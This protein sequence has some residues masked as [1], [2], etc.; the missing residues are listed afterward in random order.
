ML[1][2]EGLGKFQKKIKKVRDLYNSDKIENEIGKEFKSLVQQTFNDKRSPFGK[3]WIPSSNPD[4]LVDT[5][6]LFDSVDYEIIG[7]KVI[8][9][10]GKGL[11]YARVHNNGTGLFPERQFL[12]NEGKL[13]REWADIAFKIIQKEIRKE[14]K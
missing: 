8:V 9:S 14:I 12:P 3:S 5:G 13:P 6:A 10:A 7:S 11:T 1:K 4:T 2:L